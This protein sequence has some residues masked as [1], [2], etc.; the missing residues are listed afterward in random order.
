MEPGDVATVD[1]CA[2]VH[3]VD[4]GMFDMQGYGSVY[5]V[6]AER[7]ALVD[8]GTGAHYDRVL[9]AMDAVGVARDDLSAIVLTHVHLDHAGGAGYL[10]ETCP[11]ATVYVHELGAPHLV[12]PAR[13]VEGTKR[14][15]A[16]EWAFYAEPKPL[17][18]SRIVELS[19]G[20]TVDLG[21]RTLTAHHA[22]GHAPHQVV[23][24]DD[25]D[26]AVFTADAAGIW[27]PALDRV[28]PT[29]PPPSFDLEQCLADVETIRGLDPD[30]LLYAHFGPGR[31]DVEGAL[32]E[33][34]ATLTSWVEEVRRERER[35][36]DDDAVVE[37][38]SDRPE[39]SAVWPERRARAET[40][41]NVRGV[42]HALDRTE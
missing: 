13:L 33:Y 21:S 4:T 30:T 31:A 28:E 7:P 37:A 2:N 25:R 38:L 9:A 32:D 19:E 40:A 1:A 12:D 8:T 41:M 35:L 5:V 16:G 29:S 15:V 36:G 23:Y 22:P 10:A 26:G 34:E 3:Y 42:L 14:A 18:E 24:A 27:V 6:D 20:D 11:N 39:L 17:D